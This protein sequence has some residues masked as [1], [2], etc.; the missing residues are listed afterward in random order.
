M[1]KSIRKRVELIYKA[2]STYS[3]SELTLF[4]E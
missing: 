3:F 4:V 2:L 1:K